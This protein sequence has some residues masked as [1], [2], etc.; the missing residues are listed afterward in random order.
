MNEIE[1]LKQAI[2]EGKK[3]LDTLEWLKSKDAVSIAFENDIGDA[4]LMVYNIDRLEEMTKQEIKETENTLAVK[5]RFAE[6][7][8]I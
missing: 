5:L 8:T 2:K 3:L 7:K 1:E 4:D 6:H